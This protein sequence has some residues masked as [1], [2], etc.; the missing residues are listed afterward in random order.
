MTL[1]VKLK[2][3]DALPDLSFDL[4]KLDD[5]LAQWREKCPLKDK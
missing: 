5:A 1:A 3:K 2:K 4:A